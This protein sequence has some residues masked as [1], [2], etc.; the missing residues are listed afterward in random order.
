LV[1][2][3][4]DGFAMTRN[5]TSHKLLLGIW[6]LFCGC[7]VGGLVFFGALYFADRFEPLLALVLGVATMAFVWMASSGWQDVDLFRKA[8]RIYVKEHEKRDM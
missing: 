8:L 5:G 3:D 1:A 2:F 6:L 4:L 7:L